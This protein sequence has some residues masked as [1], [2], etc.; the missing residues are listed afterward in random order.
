MKHEF[1]TQITSEIYWSRIENLPRNAISNQLIFI[2]HRNEQLMNNKKSP[3]LGSLKSFPVAVYTILSQNPTSYCKHGSL[4]SLS[5]IIQKQL[6]SGYTL[7]KD[8]CINICAQIY[9][10]RWACM[11]GEGKRTRPTRLACSAQFSSI[12]YK[13]KRK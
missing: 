5:R 11:E 12:I 9:V 4:S 2:L 8:D 13:H 7:E 3:A 10:G 1:C 6:I